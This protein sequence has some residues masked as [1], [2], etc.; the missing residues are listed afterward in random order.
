MKVWTVAAWMVCVV[1][2]G[3][4]QGQM[5]SGPAPA[6]ERPMQERAQRGQ[7]DG[8]F[9]QHGMGAEG[10]RRGRGNG[11]DAGASPGQFDF[12]LVN[13]SWSPEFC[14]T[15]PGNAQ[16]GARPGFVLHGV[17]P[18]RNDGSYP[19]NCGGGPGPRNPSEW[20]DMMPDLHLIDHEWQTHGTCTGLA[21]DAYF[22]IARKAFRG[23]AIPPAVSGADHELM[24]P[25]AEIVDDFAKVNPS[26][27]EGSI[28]VSC[29]NNRL[30]AVEVC[31]T[32]EL[33]A[34]PCNGVRSCR[35]NVVR[36]T[37]TNAAAGIVGEG[38]QGY[39]GQQE[40]SGGGRS[41]HRHRN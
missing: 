25:A 27:P 10:G 26:F 16:C 22:A 32:K 17:W 41:R 23:I 33:K 11:A 7:R 24:L 39:G 4:R 37:P 31:M 2:V 36:I 5:G 14:Q 15:H 19:E 3:C 21:A 35:A 1:G 29:G 13:L 8:G 20:L 30:T 28:V 40:S 34:I 12:Y 6:G 18:Q 38:Q 9:E